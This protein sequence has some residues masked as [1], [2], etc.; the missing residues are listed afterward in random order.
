MHISFILATFFI[1]QGENGLLMQSIIFYSFLS[2]MQITDTE[3]LHCRGLVL[4]YL[5]VY[6]SQRSRLPRLQLQWTVSRRTLHKMKPST[7]VLLDLE[8]IMEDED[9]DSGPF[10]RYVTWNSIISFSKNFQC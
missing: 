6:H 5:T 9:D 3:L 4:E 10:D 2:L 1:A 8:P 7:R